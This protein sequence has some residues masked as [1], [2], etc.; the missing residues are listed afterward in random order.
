MAGCAE[1]HAARRDDRAYSAN[2]V[3]GSAALNDAWRIRPGRAGDLP[4]LRRMLY[5]AACWNP[6]RPR[7]TLEEALADPRTGRYLDGW[8]RPGDTAVIAEDASARPL[9]AA[10]Y[11][12]FEPAAPGYGFVDASIPELTIGVRPEHRGRGIGGALL[13]GLLDRA[14]AA[15]L[16]ALS[17][18]VERTNPALALYERHG[19]RRIGE[20]GGSWTMRIDLPRPERAGRR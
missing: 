1:E 6:D 20:S 4:F 5:E 13:T 7:P 15:G 11:R 18:S 16:D 14:R 10:W 12:F 9:G 19:F 3:P 17:L 8:G 2:P